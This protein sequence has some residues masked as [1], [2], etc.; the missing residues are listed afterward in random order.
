MQHKLTIILMQARADIK[1]NY[2]TLINKIFI[3]Y[4]LDLYV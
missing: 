2:Q 3:Y 4:F 1:N